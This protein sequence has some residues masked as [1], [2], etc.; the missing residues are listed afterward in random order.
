MHT[1]STSIYLRLCAGVL[2]AVLAPG[3][4]D[5]TGSGP[6]VHSLTI[7]G[8]PTSPLLSGS[9]VQLIAN[10]INET[11]AAVPG[12]QITWASSDT[13]IAKVSTSGLVTAVGAGAP[14][15][16]AAAGGAQGSTTLDVRAGANLGPAG[17]TLSSGT[18][19]RL[20]VPSGALQQ[21]VTLMLRPASAPPSHERMVPGT[22]WDLGPEQVGFGF[23]GATLALRYDAAKVPAGISPTSLQLHVLT[24]GAWTVVRGS[25]VD[26]TGRQASG[27]ISWTGTYAVIS[28]PTDRVVMSGA[29]VGGALYTGQSGTLSAAPLNTLGDTLPGRPI[30]WTTSDASKATVDSDGKVTAVAAGTVTITAANEGKTAS[31]TLTIL[32][33]P[34]ASWN[35]TA[36]W[37]TFQGN[38]RHTGEIAATLDPGA[39]KALWTATVH[40]SAPLNPVTT[41]DGRVFASTN[42]YFGTGAQ[43]VVALDA[44]TGGE[45]W[46]RDFGGIH[47]V[48]PPAYGGGKVYLTTG[49]HQDSYLWAFDAANG[50]VLFRSAY[51]NQWSR[52][53]APV[54]TSTAVVMAGGYYGGMYSFNAQNGTQNWFANTNQYDEWV[55]AVADGRV[56]AY[57]GEYSPRLS[58]VD[59][60]SGTE[61]Y[62]IVDPGF[63]WNGWSMHVAPVLGSSGNVLVTQGGRLLSFD[64]AGHRIGWTRTGSFKGNVTLSD[65]VAYVFNNSQVEARRESDGSLLWVWIPPEGQPLRTMAVTR[66]VLFVST[67]ANTY[68]IDL[69][70]RRHVWSYPAG[71]HLAI[72]KDGVLF[73]ARADGKLSAVSLR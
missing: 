8:A 53:Y 48:H 45:V 35:Q 2:L 49:G 14:V 64:L 55:P 22:A 19:A 15:I 34:V 4:K 11:G 30:T 3:C 18:N 43:K 54:V 13:S 72:S 12:A 41:G 58:V 21:Q 42:S 52:W 28:T 59:A 57:T 60:A 36:D 62:S 27:Q 73:I 20:T 65:G 67:A 40:A 47:S 26:V 39:F 32:A 10:A 71:G 37:T 29:L 56:Y 6:K 68:A 5:A 63:D 50:T 7:T 1:R 66:N 33:R 69:G 17:G 25:T 51:G 9:T 61:L 70:T 46:S 38:G 31:T 16:T 23:N 44:A 24:N